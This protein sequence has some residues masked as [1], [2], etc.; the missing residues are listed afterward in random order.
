MKEDEIKERLKEGG[1][2]MK[3]VFKRVPEKVVMLAVMI[4]S[5]ND[6]KTSQSLIMVS[7]LLLHARL[8]TTVF[9]PT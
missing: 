9:S 3:T 2:S 7:V 8:T 6:S 5:F 4:F 1:T